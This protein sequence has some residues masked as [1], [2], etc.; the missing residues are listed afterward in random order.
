MESALMISPPTAFAS[1]MDSAVFPAAVGPVRMSSGFLSFLFIF[2][3]IPIYS[4][5][6]FHIPQN[7]SD[8]SLKFLF[9]LMLAHGNDRRP[10]VR[11]LVW[12]LQFQKLVHQTVHFLKTHFLI[13]FHR[14]L[15]GHGCQLICDHI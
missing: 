7:V 3:P 2:L 13:P 6:S 11:A 14:R 5:F 1:R 10:A 9:Q 12:I 4:A 8:D 15:A